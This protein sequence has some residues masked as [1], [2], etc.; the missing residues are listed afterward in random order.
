MFLTS[1]MDCL[2][3]DVPPLACICLID[4]GS[5]LKLYFYPVRHYCED[6][7][8]AILFHKLFLKVFATLVVIKAIIILALREYATSTRIQLEVY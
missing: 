7:A 8:G 2:P 3:A 5:D 6:I 1:H 4:I